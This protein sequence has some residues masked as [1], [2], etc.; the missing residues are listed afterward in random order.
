MYHKIS[1]ARQANYGKGTKRMNVLILSDSHGRTSKILQAIEAQPSSPDA[2][3]FLG[4]G[5]RDIAYCELDGIPLYAVCGNC[6]FYSIYGEVRG[7]NE[8]IADLGG[9]RVMM[10]HGNDY[11]VK[12]GLGTIVAAAS[13]KDVDIVLFGHTHEPLEKYLPEGE[14]E[15]GITLKKSLYLFNPGSIGGYDA[16]FGVLNIDKRGQIL[17]SHGRA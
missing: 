8:I 3:V 1:L 14:S 9:K 13:R 15:Y 7:E 6:D 16:S 5:L 12:S 2:I 17:L 10:T 4:D 11:G